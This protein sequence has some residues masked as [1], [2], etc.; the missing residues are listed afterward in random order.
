MESFNL[1][2]VEIECHICGRRVK[3]SELEDHLKAHTA[4]E[5]KTPFFSKTGKCVMAVFGRI[6]V[7]AKI[8]GHEP[9][10]PWRVYAVDTHGRPMM[11]DL[12]RAFIVTQ[13]SEEEFQ[14]ASKKR[15][16]KRSKATAEPHTGETPQ[17]EPKPD[18]ESPSNVDTANAESERTRF[19]DRLG[20]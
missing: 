6:I 8:V 5:L 11:M 19:G 15:R 17:Q 2:G 16:R 1:D 20:H 4:I 7:M 13:I 9:M 14:A 12:R 18:T 10:N 3:A